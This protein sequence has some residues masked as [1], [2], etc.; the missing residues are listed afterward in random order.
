MLK[1]RVFQHVPVNMLC[2]ISIVTLALD[3]AVRFL[4]HIYIFVSM[5]INRTIAFSARYNL[6]DVRQT[7]WHA[8]VTTRRLHSDNV[9]QRWIWLL[10]HRFTCH[11][12]IKRDF[13]WQDLKRKFDIAQP[14][15]IP[16]NALSEVRNQAIFPTSITWT[17]AIRCVRHERDAQHTERGGY[18]ND[19]L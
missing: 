18:N 11:V 17:C 9:C 8:W 4:F 5:Q 14:H 3:M 6:G 12:Y 7:C 13:Y 2:E 16:L 10:A 1:C 15:N 19:K